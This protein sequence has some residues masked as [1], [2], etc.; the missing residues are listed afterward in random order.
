MRK[1]FTLLTLLERMM[2]TN[3]ITINRKNKAALIMTTANRLSP[4]G[5]LQCA[6]A[7]APFWMH[8]AGVCDLVL[9]AEA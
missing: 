5:L 3:P 9:E 8:R 1:H 6:A 7:G 4:D 2:T